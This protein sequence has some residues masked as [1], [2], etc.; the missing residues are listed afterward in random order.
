MTIVT[1][2]VQHGEITVD[3]TREHHTVTVER[4][5]SIF[6]LMECFE[7]ECISHTDRRAMIAVTPGDII[8]VFDEAYTR[9]IRINEFAYLFVVAFELQLCLR[10]IPVDSIRTETDMQTHT[11][12]GIVATEHA[13]ITSLERNDSTVEHTV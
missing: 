2:T 5:I 11:A 1:R 12:V 13:G 4:Q 3:L 7:I 8:A 9:V 6:Q 10:N